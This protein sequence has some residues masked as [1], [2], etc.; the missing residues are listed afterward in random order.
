[1]KKV[2]AILVNW[3]KPVDTI[4]AVNSLLLAQGTFELE[5]LIVDNASTDNSL[6]RFEDEFKT[7]KKISILKNKE[8]L[9]FT[10][11]NNLGIKE[12][13]KNKA[14]FLLIINNDTYIDKNLVVELLAT[15]ETYPEAGIASPKIYFA[16]GFEYHKKYS[17]AEIG[18]VIWYAGGEMDWD[19]VYGKNRGVDEVDRGQYDKET[20]LDFAT[21]AC[22][23]VAFKLIKKIGMFNNSYF[24]YMED[25]EFSQRAKMAGYKIIYNPKAV[26]WHKVSQSSGIGS[27]LNDYYITRNRLLFGMRY[28]SLRTKLALLKESINFLSY[29]RQWQRKGILDFALGKL[30]KGSFK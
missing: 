19:N 14:D 16:P 27:D 2:W 26:L 3:N 8:N 7:N 22:M 17:K 10:G 1:M 23:M 5:V 28:A 21:G 9:G 24:A 20:E 4:D 12:A 29:G 15:F 30:G 13:I 18:K 11:G 25:V 6:I